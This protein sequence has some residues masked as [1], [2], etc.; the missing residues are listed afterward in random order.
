VQVSFE[1]LLTHIPKQLCFPE[2]H[3]FFQ[4]KIQTSLL[5]I[6]EQKIVEKFE[7]LS[8]GATS[9]KPAPRRHARFAPLFISF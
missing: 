2:A 4:F 7:N 1:A 8:I 3:Q 5:Q 9:G 6:P